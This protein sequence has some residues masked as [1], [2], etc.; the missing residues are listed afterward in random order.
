[1]Y[2]SGGSVRLVTSHPRSVL[3]SIR[4]RDSFC[5]SAS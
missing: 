5:V 2:P 1:V 4:S 3:K